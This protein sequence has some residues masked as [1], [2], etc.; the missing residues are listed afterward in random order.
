MRTSPPDIWRV[1]QKKQRIALIYQ[2]RWLVIVVHVPCSHLCRGKRL[3][4]RLESF[5]FPP[6]E[7]PLCQGQVTVDYVDR[8]RTD[9]FRPC[10]LQSC[11]NFPGKL[12]RWNYVLAVP[13]E[14]LDGF[15]RYKL[16][17]QQSLSGEQRKRVRHAQSGN[18]QCRQSPHF[19]GTGIAAL[20]PSP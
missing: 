15:A 4:R 12:R 2:I 1:D 11:Q 16:Y 18:L 17:Q 8:H 5:F 13:G 6:R 20:R 19:F 10:Q 7:A 14:S 9:A 3:K